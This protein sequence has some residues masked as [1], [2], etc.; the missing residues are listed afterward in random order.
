MAQ[1]VLSY[2]R[3]FQVW[4]YTVSH[5]QLLLRSTKDAENRTQVDVLFKNVLSVNLPTLLDDLCVEL[6]DE[7]GATGVTAQLGAW[8]L[9]DEKMF[10]VWGRN[11]RGYVVAGI[12]V[13]SEDDQEH[14]EPSPLLQLPG[15]WM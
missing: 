4:T 3:R 8:K 1:L 7:E 5:G 15:R 12:V 11:F 13:S 2:K 10:L 9:F 6:A 14:H